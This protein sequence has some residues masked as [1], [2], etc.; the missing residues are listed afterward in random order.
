MEE[1][2]HGAVIH[3]RRVGLYGVTTVEPVD[4]GAYIYL[5]G[6]GLVK[7]NAWALAYFPDGKPSDPHIYAHIYGPW[8]EWTQDPDA[9][10]L[11][12]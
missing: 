5:H 12:S 11:L 10:L 6:G 8:Y 7:D 3:D 2:Q 1:V 4:S 9:G